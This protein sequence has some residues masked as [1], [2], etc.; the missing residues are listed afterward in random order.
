MSRSQE[1]QEA[2][3]QCRSRR[4]SR[5]Q[6]KGRVPAGAATNV[7]QPGQEMSPHKRAAAEQAVARIDRHWISAG[8]GGDRGARGKDGFQEELQQRVAAR[9]TGCTRYVLA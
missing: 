2:R 7:W 8:V 9:E 4:E 1:R 6:G 3:D 5:N